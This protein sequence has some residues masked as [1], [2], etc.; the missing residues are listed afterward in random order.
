MERIE[1]GELAFVFFQAAKSSVGAYVLTC[2]FT[3]QFTLA[4]GWTVFKD[5]F[6]MDKSK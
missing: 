2:S 3:L 6:F 4:E 1:I 5:F